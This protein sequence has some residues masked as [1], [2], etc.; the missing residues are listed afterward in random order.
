MKKFF[1]FL[2]F[3]IPIRSLAFKVSEPHNK[4]ETQFIANYKYGFLLPHSGAVNVLTG[5]MFSLYEFGVE[6]PYWGNS[7][8]IINYPSHRFGIVA[9]YSPLSNPELLGFGLSILPYLDLSLFEGNST[10]IK[11]RVGSG[12]AYIEKPF[13]LENNYQN[14]V[15]GSHINNVTDFQFKFQYKITRKTE[16]RLGFGLQHFSN[17]SYKRPN[18][19]L[20]IPN[21]NAGIKY[22]LKDFRIKS[23]V[24]RYTSDSSRAFITLNHGAKNLDFE[25]NKRY[26][27]IN[28]AGGYSFAFKKQRYIHLRMDV[29]Y[30][31]S[32]PYLKDFGRTLKP[33]DNWILGLFA[34]YEKKFGYIGLFFGSGYYVHSIYETFDQDWSLKNK[35]GNFYNRVGVKA[36]YKN[37]YLS[38]GVKTH[39]GEADNMEIGLGYRFK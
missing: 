3:L 1:I 15:I 27:V 20:N 19:G 11:L 17:G 12:L 23:C 33:I 2:I 14:L 7:E 9:N 28:L 5:G 30:D 32:I 35:G 39:T 24:R 29:I 6:F 13:D 18:L 38:A 34:T 31:E 4:W 8:F 36:Y 25:G 10:N 26:N 22:S 16:L 21:L 37:I